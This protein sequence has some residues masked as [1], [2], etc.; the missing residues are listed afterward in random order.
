MIEDGIAEWKQEVDETSER[1]RAEYWFYRRLVECVREKQAF[2]GC[3]DSE[4]LYKI[5]E[6]A[7]RTAYTCHKEHPNGGYG[8]KS[9]FISAVRGHR[10]N[11]GP[12][13]D[14]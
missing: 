8:I 6:Y 5:V 11:E 12:D 13:L 10:R 14:D 9:K 3:T 4:S 2:S 7:L 1:E